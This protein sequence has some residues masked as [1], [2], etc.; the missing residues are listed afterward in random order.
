MVSWISNLNS[1][2]LFC[3][4]GI[5]GN[6]ECIFP[7]PDPRIHSWFFF[8]SCFPYIVDDHMYIFFFNLL[9]WLV[10]ST[11][12]FFWMLNQH[13]ITGINSSWPEFTI[14][15]IYCW[16]VK[17]LFRNLRRHFICFHERLCLVTFYVGF[18]C[19]GYQDNIGLIAS[20]EKYFLLWNF[21]EFGLESNQIISLAF[22]RIHQWS[23]LDPVVFFFGKAFK[24]KFSFFLSFFFF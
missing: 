2:H 7:G 11:D 19:F 21:E 3:S 24:Y 9:I 4:T 23:H 14:L 17:I 1:W 12:F 8:N 22:I 20:V 18:L 13:R 16:V 5:F 6:V 15:C 10:A